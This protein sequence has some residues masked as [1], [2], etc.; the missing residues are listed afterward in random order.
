MPEPRGWPDSEEELP[1]RDDD[2]GGKVPFPPEIEDTT[3]GHP[4]EPHMDDI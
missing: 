3:Q 4:N 2:A 1:P